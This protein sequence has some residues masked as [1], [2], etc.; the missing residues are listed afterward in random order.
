MGKM[1]ND[2]RNFTSG[3]AILREILFPIII[4]FIL[5]CFSKYV[6]STGN[7][8]GY[9]ICI[10]ISILAASFCLYRLINVFFFPDKIYNKA[11]DYSV[12]YWLMNIV[13]G[14]KDKITKKRS[15][16][17][18]RNSVN[19]SK[20]YV[21]KIYPSTLIE[22]DQYPDELKQALLKCWSYDNVGKA[23]KLA[24][25]VVFLIK[26]EK[27]HAQPNYKQIVK[28]FEDKLSVKIDQTQLVNECDLIMRITKDPSEYTNKANVCKLMHYRIVEE[29]LSRFLTK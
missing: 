14:L 15:A 23:L 13:H 12:P 17:V 5:G 2:E 8:L 25:P 18:N 1:T 28:F 9:T 29:E 7:A 24:A 3:F 4:L 20:T 22:W 21:A 27:L 6:E 10:A 11:A 16:T 26:A 19:C